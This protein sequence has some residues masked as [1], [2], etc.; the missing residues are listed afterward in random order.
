MKTKINVTLVLPAPV[1]YI[2]KQPFPTDCMCFLT[3]EPGCCTVILKPPLRQLLMRLTHP[4]TAIPHG[5]LK[6]SHLS[7]PT[8][9][10]PNTTRWRI[11]TLIFPT[12]TTVWVVRRSAWCTS[13]GKTHVYDKHDPVRWITWGNHFD[14]RNT[15]MWP[16]LKQRC[17]KNLSTVFNLIAA[18]EVRYNLF[19]VKIQS[20]GHGLCLNKPN[21]ISYRE[22]EAN[23]TQHFQFWTTVKG[24]S[25]QIVVLFCFAF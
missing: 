1:L 11:Q 18:R 23:R 22:T 17:L 24:K 12:I 7:P 20:F 6:P 9:W 4:S 19:K 3:D 2:H 25:P 13:L 21:G 8:P 16:L 10:N 5:R 15:N 14:R